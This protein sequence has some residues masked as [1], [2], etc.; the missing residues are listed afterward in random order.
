MAQPRRST[1]ESSLV[2]LTIAQGLIGLRDRHL[3]PPHGLFR[4]SARG[5]RFKHDDL[6]FNLL[7]EEPS[8]V[9]S[10]CFPVDAETVGVE[11]SGSRRLGHG[12]R[13]ALPP[14]VRPTGQLRPAARQRQNHPLRIPQVVPLHIPKA[15]RHQPLRSRRQHVP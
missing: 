5:R 11:P 14:A 1:T 12:R 8:E 3:T 10:C 9:A 15:Q 4:R 6:A 13:R 2:R 7:I